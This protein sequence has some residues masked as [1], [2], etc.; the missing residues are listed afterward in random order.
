[1]WAKPAL[2]SRLGRHPGHISNCRLSQRLDGLPHLV[3]R[4]LSQR[5]TKTNQ[6]TG[7][8]KLLR[9]TGLSQHCVGGVPGQ[10][11]AVHREAPLRNRTVPDFMVAFTWPL[12]VTSM[13]AKNF[14]H[15][16][17]VAGHQKVRTP[18]SSC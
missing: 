7:K 17:G 5:T 1:M 10:D 18:L 9:D 11:F 8:S 13:S 16:G 12:E 3:R 14:L 2:A 4:P 15:A 6:D